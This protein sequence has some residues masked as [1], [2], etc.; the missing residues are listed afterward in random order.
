MTKDGG[1][2]RK[3]T[4]GGA[5]IKKTLGGAPIKKDPRRGSDLALSLLEEQDGAAAGR[6]V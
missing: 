6:A 5:P 1:G 3:K 4:L 2:S